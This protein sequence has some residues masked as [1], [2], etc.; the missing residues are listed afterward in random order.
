MRYTESVFLLR[1]AN[2]QHP[3][4]LECSESTRCIIKI[5]GEAIAVDLLELIVYLA[6][7]AGFGWVA[8]RLIR[9]ANPGLVGNI[10]LGITG[11]LFARLLFQFVGI[12]PQETIDALILATSGA[13]CLIFLVWFLDQANKSVENGSDRRGRV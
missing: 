5:I 1:G 10:I 12:A 4:S 11:A 2:I 7:G 8:Q 9:T 13:G 3:F 6:V